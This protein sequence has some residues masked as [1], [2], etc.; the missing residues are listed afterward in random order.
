MASRGIPQIIYHY[1]PQAFV[2][3]YRK[4]GSAIRNMAVIRFQANNSKITQLVIDAITW[5]HQS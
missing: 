1:F 3:Y 4:N 2:H 5:K